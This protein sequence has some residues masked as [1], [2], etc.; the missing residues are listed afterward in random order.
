MKELPPC[1]TL[2]GLNLDPLQGV[3]GPLFYFVLFCFIVVHC[4]INRG[5]EQLGAH[6]V[7]VGKSFRSWIREIFW[8]TRGQL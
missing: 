6:P 5:N 2:K 4:V 7:V 3:A 8:L 1:Q